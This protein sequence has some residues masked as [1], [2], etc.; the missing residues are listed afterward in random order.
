MNGVFR[1]KNLVRI[2]VVRKTLVNAVIKEWNIDKPQIIDVND[3]LPISL[4]KT[5]KRAIIKND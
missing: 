4:G 1:Q 2:L 3:T 5:I